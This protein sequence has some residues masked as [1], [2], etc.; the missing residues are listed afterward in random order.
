MPIFRVSRRRPLTALGSNPFV[1][2]GA[3]MRAGL[4]VA[5]AGCTA[6]DAGTV[7]DWG[8]TREAGGPVARL[9]AVPF[10]SGLA[11]ADL[12]G[13]PERNEGALAPGNLGGSVQWIQPPAAEWRHLLGLS[14]AGERLHAF[15]SAASLPASEAAAGITIFSSSRSDAEWGGTVAILNVA[16][17]NPHFFRALSHD[18]RLHSLLSARS[19]SG[20][21]RLMLATEE[22]HGWVVRWLDGTPAGYP[23]IVPGEGP[24]L[25][26]V[27]VGGAPAG[28]GVDANSV[29]FTRIT[30]AGASTPVLVSRSGA[31]PAYEPTL[32][33]S[34]GRLDIVWTKDLDGDTSTRE[35]LWHAHSL[36]S[37]ESWSEPRTIDAGGHIRRLQLLPAAGGPVVLYLKAPANGMPST[38]WR[39]RLHA[40]RL[41]PAQFLARS[42]LSDYIASF[43][44]DGIVHLLFSTISSRGRPAATYHT[45]GTCDA[46]RFRT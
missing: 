6:G 21:H 10:E 9:A 44:D 29:W 28:P 17:V 1:T 35:A 8:P 7:C 41:T 42:D 2:A 40:R 34:A 18:G 22:E 39:A 16:G 4:T 32:L 13:S 30:P 15:W 43:A 45:V 26:L 19:G 25:L 31:N 38:L 12:Q 14:A 11:A 33:H 24:D 20:R 27:S 37:G 3:A 36:D 23:D 46:V 5:L